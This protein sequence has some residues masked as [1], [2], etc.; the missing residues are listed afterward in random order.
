VIGVPSIRRL[1]GV[2]ISSIEHHPAVVVAML[3]GA[4]AVIHFLP[5]R[6]VLTVDSF[7]HLSNSFSCSQDLRSWT[8]LTSTG[9]PN[10]SL[11]LLPA[12]CSLVVLQWTHLPLWITEALFEALLGGS[13]A[14]GMYRMV[15]RLTQL[16]DIN[17]CLAPAI[18]AIFWVANP[19]SLSYVWYHVLYL[20]VLWA[21][22]PWLCFSVLAAKGGRRT[23]P[24]VCAG[25][26]VATII[27]SP[28]LTEGELPQTFL[29]LLFLAVLM[30]V[31][32][33]RRV[34]VRSMIIIGACAF[35][36]L[37]WLLPSLSN[38]GGLYSTAA[39]GLNTSAVLRFASGYS[40]VWHLLTFVAVPQLYQ[41]V[42]GTPYIAW[43]AI[44]TSSWGKAAVVGIPV[45]GAV[46][47]AVLIKKMRL[48]PVGPL[49]GML[50]LGIGVC[51]GLAN[52]FPVTGAWLSHLPFGALFRQPLNDFGLL[53]LFPM[54]VFVGFGGDRV[55]RFVAEYP[56][57]GRWYHWDAGGAVAA[58]S[59]LVATAVIVVP[60][61]TPLVFPVGGGI[62]PSATYSIPSDYAK[63]GRLLAQAPAGGKTLVLPFSS[64]GE[65][66][67]VW[68]S[69]VQANTDPLF[70]AWQTHRTVLENAHGNAGN[71]GL[72]VAHCIADGRQGCVRLAEY[73]GFD[74]L[75]IHKDWN[76]AYMG[77]DIAIPSPEVSLKYFSGGQGSSI[78]VNRSGESLSVSSS[79][80]LSLWVDVKS[81]PAA[82]DRFLSFNGFYLQLNHQNFFGIYSPS[83]RIWDP[84]SSLGSSASAYLTLAW[85]RHELRFWVDGIQQGTAVPFTG[86]QP[87]EVK[88]LAPGAAPGTSIATSGLVALR[89]PVASCGVV[90]C[91]LRR[92]VKLLFTGS[93]LTLFS[94][95]HANPLLGASSCESSADQPEER[96]ASSLQGGIFR[97]R[98]S[99]CT[100]VEFRETFDRGW[101]LIA[102]SRGAKVTQHVMALGGYNEWKV[103]GPPGAR[104][105][106]R[107]APPVSVRLMLTLG[108]LGALGYLFGVLVFS[109][110]MR[111][112]RAR[113]LPAK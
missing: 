51:K 15:C 34:F 21:V 89:R 38:L 62:L 54:T 11:G 55:A 10:T 1:I 99:G 93:Y 13:A 92:G 59:L 86:K 83:R 17:A 98:S 52:P 56:R 42:N 61:W 71:P 4:G 41:T 29:I 90:P 45:L 3:V 104:Y 85:S 47:V 91:G 72:R 87:R 103:Y 7:F 58:V 96:L 63:V 111:T 82:E 112:R 64:N 65:S 37:W 74:R 76:L 30:G 32:Y 66:A 101:S 46:G 73:F 97:V 78:P 16:L 57:G 75:V 102:D 22:L 94:L 23:L 36:L 105:T 9:G 113:S 79:G 81:I 77:T 19:F 24:S 2:V 68:P 33:G 69:G 84:G 31:V 106:L 80:S 8:S 28:G 109:R 40:T 60:W 39:A 5:G 12:D 18:A 35:G 44:A 95:R 43:S 48:R 110:N 108:V 25:A 20:Q 107:Y 26:L 88:V 70:E 100:Y 27:G 14:L 49:L 50:V 53:I 67:F 6:P